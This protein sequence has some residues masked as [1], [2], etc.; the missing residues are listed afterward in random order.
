MAEY[1]AASDGSTLG[2]VALNPFFHLFCNCVNVAY[3]DH[4]HEL[5]TIRVA[6]A[7]ILFMAIFN[8]I[9]SKPGTNLFLE[10]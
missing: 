8:L 6:N 9:L 4:L 10:L 3:K 2:L 7:Q 1:S 5:S